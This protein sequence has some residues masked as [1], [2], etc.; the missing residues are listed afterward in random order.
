M[1]LVT[2][3]IEIVDHIKSVAGWA[4][5]SAQHNQQ[6]LGCLCVLYAKLT[7]HRVRAYL[8]MLALFSPPV[9]SLGKGLSFVLI[10]VTRRTP[11]KENARVESK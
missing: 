3:E 1:A 2:F 10:V 8:F 11:W 5:M 6:H 7:L 9:Q 4:V